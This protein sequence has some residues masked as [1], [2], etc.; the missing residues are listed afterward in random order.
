MKKQ[1]MFQLAS[2][3]LATALLLGC[4]N[5][6]EPGHTASKTEKSVKAPVARA[7]ITQRPVFY[8]AVGTVTARTYSTLSSKL[9]GTVQTVHVKEGDAVKEGDLLVS[10]D[11]RQVTA[12]LDQ[13]AAALDE[14]RRGET[15]AESAKETAN[16][17]YELAKITHERYVRLLKNE[18]VS[19]QEFDEVDARRRQTQ[20]S[21]AQA[22]AMLQAARHR[23]KQGAAALDAA[24]VAKKDARILAPYNGR[25]TRKMVNSGDLASPG[26]PL[27]VI[28]K[29]GFFDAE[30]LLP[31]R[32]IRWVKSKQEVSV[33]IPAVGE[34]PIR[35]MI[36]R[37]FPGADEKSRSFELK[38]Q[39]PRDENIRSGMFARVFVPLE[40]KPMLMVPKKA[41]VFQGQLTGIFVLDQS[42]VA[43]LRPVRYGKESDDSVEI[44]SG[45]NEGSRYV[46]DPPPTLES[47]NK[48]EVT[49]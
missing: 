35:G 41:L 22:E 15:A 45:L 11:E 5:K 31:E 26:T 1:P 3:L 17:A 4:G 36:E 30:I 12:L 38:I 40:E 29:E 13:A 8:E 28:E 21:Q 7:T 25:I 46:T 20:A 14:V 34:R 18:S 37:I 10:L 42:E 47:G 32:H 6:I 39:L 27:A 48:V 19:R 23:V 2:S 49:P 16:A 9:L 33:S 43:R 24:M 44:L